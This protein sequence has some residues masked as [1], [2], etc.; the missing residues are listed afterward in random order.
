MHISF[1]CQT[2]LRVHTCVHTVLLKPER[3]RS[4]AKPP[5]CGYQ[6]WKTLHRLMHRLMRH[7][8][9]H[10]MY[11]LFY[12]LMHQLMCEQGRMEWQRMV[13]DKEQNTRANGCVILSSCQLGSL[14]TSLCPP[15]WSCVRSCVRRLDAHVCVLSVGRAQV[16]RAST[17]PKIQQIKYILPK[18]RSIIKRIN[19]VDHI[20]LD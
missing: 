12:Q 2:Y 7:L 5:A 14:C 11:H 9:H 1:H 10:R 3:A 19:L 4:R 18:F 20:I 8:T 6:R 16:S 15:L 17:G 13:V